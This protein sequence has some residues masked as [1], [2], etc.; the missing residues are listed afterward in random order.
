MTFSSTSDGKCSA[1][2][3]SKLSNCS[4]KQAAIVSRIRAKKIYVFDFY[5]VYRNV[6]NTQMKKN[7]ITPIR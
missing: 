2:I 4:S 5:H 6:D 1:R 7:E 3:D